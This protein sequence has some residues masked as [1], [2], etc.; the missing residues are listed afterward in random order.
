MASQDWLNKDFYT[1]LGVAKDA[2]ETDIKKAYRKLAKNLHPD[3]NPGD[4]AG[5]L[6]FKEV[7]EA[8][9]V[10]SDPEQRKQYDAIRSMTSGGA[11]F[12]S[13][14][15]GPGGGGQFED[16]F[17]TMFG[18]PGG[19]A[20]GA[21]GGPR[22]RFSTGGPGGPGG[23]GGAS[24]EDLLGGMF[25]G[26]AGASYGGYGAP[27]GPQRGADIDAATTL[28]FRQ[29]VHGETV[30]LRTQE[31]RT[32][33]VRIPAGVRDGQRIRLAGKGQPGDHGAPAGDM[34]VSVKVTPHPV[35]GR[36]GDNLTITVPVA[37]DEAALGSTLE[38]PTLDGS[39]VKVKLPA[40]TPSGRVL[41]VKGRGVER[42]GHPKGDLLAK[43]EVAVPQRLS[44]E[45][46]EAV[47]AFR[48]ATDGED[49]RADLIARAKES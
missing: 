22:V 41:R 49:P 18:G 25:G 30:Q 2:S 46:R 5:E 19:G 3:R 23:P 28:G 31:G 27:R 14:G 29:A 16:V 39:T 17:S 48:A 37:F 7:G 34:V 4:E 6:R 35:F 45:A 13:G 40:G 11:R 47:E 21:A 43:V 32:I 38:V 26:G 44:D 1:L 12:T 24:L 42:K 33:T 10:L 20:G 8:Y 9:S 36:E 15:R